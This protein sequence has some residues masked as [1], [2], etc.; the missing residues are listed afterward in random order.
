M[1][2]FNTGHKENNTKDKIVSFEQAKTRE[3]IKNGE[4]HKTLFGKIARWFE[5]LKLVAFTGSY[6]DLSGKPSSFPPSSHTHTK[7]QIP[8]FAHKH[9]KADITDFPSSL[10]ASDVPAWAK[11]TSKPSYSWSEIGSKPSTF[12]PSSHTHADYA[13]KSRY[14]DTNVSVGR[15]AGTATN[16]RS[17][18]FGS[19][20]EASGWCSYAH[21]NFC[22]AS[23]RNS[24]ATGE[25][26]VS[27][28][29]TT[30]ADG[31]E[32][33][34]SNYYSHAEGAATKA[35]G[36]CSHAT[37]DRTSAPGYCNTAIGKYNVEQ[38]ML[39]AIGNGSASARSN[40]FSVSSSG[41]VKAAS[42]ITASTAADYAEYFEWADGNPGSEDRTGMFVTL[43][44]DKIRL[45]DA[46]D[47]YIL[48]IVSGQPFVLGNG[49]CDVWNGMVERDVFGR[50]VYDKVPVTRKLPA[51]KEG[52]TGNI[53]EECPVYDG[54][55]EQ[56][57]EKVP[58][59]NPAYDSTQEY[60]PRAERKEWSPVGMLGVL[61]V[62]DDGTCETNG[63]CRCNKDAVATRSET[64]YRVIGRLSENVV[65]VIVK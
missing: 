35:T 19:E 39:F 10:P 6:N 46:S 52:S 37:G 36:L 61:S 55:G 3:N 64:G 56:E 50:V 65:R 59:I 62:Y 18:A 24:Y 63:Y 8:D 48:G 13:L 32:T 23:G 9:T 16:D 47:S 5:D 20:V 34:A 40:A 15:K 29:Y 22:E 45:A 44:G 28:G 21:G 42:T 1:N 33:E 54:N 25:G 31:W 41:V 4:S 26:A 57:Y 30:Y 51:A 2:W 49:D 53:L 12:P 60:I 17:F 7:S 14:G 38:N 43:E 11:Q 58:R 27:T